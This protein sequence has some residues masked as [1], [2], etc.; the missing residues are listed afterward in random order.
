MWVCSLWLWPADD[1]IHYSDCSYSTCESVLYDCDL[2][3]ITSTIL[4][5]VTAH[6]SLFSTIASYNLF[7]W[8]LQ[9]ALTSMLQW[10]VHA[11]FV[12]VMP[13]TSP[14]SPLRMCLAFYLVSLDRY[15]AF[16]RREKNSKKG[17]G[18]GVNLKQEWLLAFFWTLYSKRHVKVLCYIT[19]TWG[20]QATNT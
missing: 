17:G 14:S 2:L 19:V 1:N 7:M 18:G 15:L 10:K 9:A 20:K 11:S 12:S 8:W 16:Y 13:S 4:I 6:V 3:M 5:V